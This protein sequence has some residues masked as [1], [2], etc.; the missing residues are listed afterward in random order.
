MIPRS[1]YFGDRAPFPFKRSGVMRIFE[2]AGLKAFLLTAGRRAHYPGEQPNASIEQDKGRRLAARKH[3]VTDRHRDNG[4][5][6]EKSLVDALEPAA[7]HRYAG[8]G[9]ELAHQR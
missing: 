3:I 6:L 5:G 1:Q 7:Q 8:A 4:T 9:G 2:K